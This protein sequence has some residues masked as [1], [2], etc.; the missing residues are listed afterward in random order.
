MQRDL[1][2]KG[3]I[4]VLKII[5]IP[6]FEFQSN[7]LFVPEEFVSQ[8]H[9]MIF[10]FLWNDK[11]AKIKGETVIADTEEGGLRMPHFPTIVASLKV[12][13]IKRL[14]DEKCSKWKKLAWTLMNISEF[15]LMCKHD[16]SLLKPLSSFYSQV[17][18]AWYSLYSKT[19][20]GVEEICTEIIWNNK[21][22]TVGGIPVFYRKWYDNGII[23][24]KDILSESGEILTLN[25]LNESYKL[26]IGFMEY[27]SLKNSIPKEWIERLKNNKLSVETKEMEKSF[28]EYVAKLQSSKVYWKMI[29]KYIKTPTAIEQ[30]ISEFPFFDDTDFKAIFML[31]AYTTKDTKLH[32]FQYKIL[33][34]IFPCNYLLTKWKIKND[35]ACSYC[36]LPDTIEHYFYEC[37]ECKTFWLFVENWFRKISNVYIPLRITNILFGIPFKQSQDKMLITLNFIIL[38]GKWYLYMCKREQ[39][40]IFTLS[41]LKYLKHVLKIEKEINIVRKTEHEFDETWSFIE[42]AL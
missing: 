1:S 11:P 18:E 28:H 26:N 24:V 21:H 4:T 12:L 34:R 37:C 23:Q 7:N 30:W 36:N 39:K 42:H 5:L 2:L 16:S 29:V 22:L 13:W 19:P 8:I 14:L 10:K 40:C 27:C 33:H 6:T 35:I 31:P 3:K 32:C 41:F 20:V 17:L 9:K 25:E 15:D 38:H